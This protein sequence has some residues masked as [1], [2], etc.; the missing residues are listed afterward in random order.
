MTLPHHFAGV[1]GILPTNYL[2][3]LSFQVLVHRKE[4]LDFELH[5]RVHAAKVLHLFI[6][7]IIKPDR[8]QLLVLYS[9]VNHLK[10]ANWPHLN[11]TAGK[12]GRVYQNQDIKRIPIFAEGTGYESVITGVVHR[13][14]KIAIETKDMK[15]LVVFVFVDFAARDLHYHVHFF[16]RVIAKRQAKI[17]SH[18]IANVCTLPQVSLRY[19]KFHKVEM[20]SFEPSSRSM[21]SWHT[22]S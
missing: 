5:V 22:A 20:S 12:A 21:A 18:G 6:V 4:V 2:S 17:I 1:L 7:R 14:M 8:Q 10:H 19:L 11:Y 9:L 3:S 16:R 15:H 13:R